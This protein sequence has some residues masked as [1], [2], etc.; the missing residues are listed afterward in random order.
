M[1]CF[2]FTHSFCRAWRTS[3]RLRVWKQPGTFSQVLQVR[4]Q[5]GPSLLSTY[6]AQ[7][8]ANAFHKS[9]GVSCC[10]R[11][12]G[13][14]KDKLMY[15]PATLEKRKIG[16]ILIANNHIPPSQYKGSAHPCSEQK[17]VPAFAS[18]QDLV[19]RSPTRL[20]HKIHFTR[21]EVS[22]TKPL[23]T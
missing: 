12:R 8:I 4:R 17:S 14:H 15:E 23:I 6:R 13:Y 9:S 18:S 7:N 21:A 16:K 10:T 1:T 11:P 20:M 5:S 2:S 22:D 19:Y 3:L